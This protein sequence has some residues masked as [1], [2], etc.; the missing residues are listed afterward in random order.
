L[1]WSHIWKVS[2]WDLNVENLVHLT[3][4]DPVSLFM[5]TENS[6]AAWTCVATFR[7]LIRELAVVKGNFALI[8][9]SRPS[10]GS[11]IA[12]AGFRLMS[13]E[14]SVICFLMP[15]QSTF[16]KMLMFQSRHGPCSVPLRHVSVRDKEGLTIFITRVA[17]IQNYGLRFYDCSLMS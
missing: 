2:F 12:D 17:L 13:M 14:I 16:R 6:P 5:D 7:F 15:P 4:N 10:D 1:S 3:W 11:L 9:I 8:F